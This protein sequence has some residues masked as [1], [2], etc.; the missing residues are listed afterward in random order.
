MRWRS[1]LLASLPIVLLAIPALGSSRRDLHACAE[2]RTLQL[3]IEGCTR[4]LDHARLATRLR[5]QI[6]NA[7]GNAY[8]NLG[9]LN[10]AIQDYTTSIELDPR[11]F[12]AYN[13]RANALR[14]AGAF[15]QAIADYNAALRLRPD[16][17][18]IYAGRAAAWQEKGNFRQALADYNEAIR[19]NPRA[20]FSFNNRGLLWQIVGE[21]DRSIAD[22][23]EAIRLFP[24]YQTAYSNRGESWRLKGDLNLALA[25]EDRA[26]RMQPRDPLGY[27]RRGDIYRYKGNLNDALADYDIALRLAPDYTPAL[28]DRGLTYEKMGDRAR[29]KAEFEKALISPA[30][31][32]SSIFASAQAT[33]RAQL[34]ALEAGAPQPVIPNAPSTVTSPTSIPTPAVT[35]PKAVPDALVPH[36]RRVALVIGNSAYRSVTALPNPTRDAQKVADTLRNIGFDSVTLATDV[37]HDRLIEVLGEFARQAKSADWALVYYA[38]HGVEMNGVNYL[39]PVDAKLATDRVLE[40]VG[41]D[42]VMASMAGAKKLKLVLLDACR[43][44]PFAAKAGQSTGRQLV[45][46][47]PATGAPLNARA[48]GRGLAKVDVTGATLVEFAAKDGQVALDGQGGDSPFAVAVVQRI[49]TPNVE[50]SKVF[51]LVRDDVMEATAGRQEPYTYGSLPGSEDFY[52]VQTRTMAVH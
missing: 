20:P 25:D 10:R 48:I 12:Q 6:F 43:S 30:Q 45:V 35:V 13:N 1:I 27:L 26:I 7:R 18:P 50:I 37:T 32:H 51:R 19:L 14:N 46:A 34:A 36:G 24:N 15:D 16:I 11:S 17:G 47:R 3:R 29:A 4:L 33:A 31:N 28:T 38:G 39:I 9:D 40:T 49:A 41:L 2:G 23:T 52:F 21:Y 44:N 5:A 42:Q 8:K 22:F